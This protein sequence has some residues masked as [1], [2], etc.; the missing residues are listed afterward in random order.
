MMRDYD[1]FDCGVNVISGIV[2]QLHNSGR[3]SCV[4]L[5]LIS[6]STRISAVL[7]LER[8]N[9]IVDFWRRLSAFDNSYDVLENVPLIDALP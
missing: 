5:P 8:C 3:W 4:R 6:N 7:R 9:C 2:S 1:A